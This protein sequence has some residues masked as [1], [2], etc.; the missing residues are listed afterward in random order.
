MRRRRGVVAGFTVLHL[1]AEDGAGAGRGGATNDD[2]EGGAIGSEARVAAAGAVL[3]QDICDI[4]QRAGEQFR[5]EAGGE[6]GVAGEW[7]E[8]VEDQRL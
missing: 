4:R 7:A 6:R 1:D 3:E 5:H 8:Q 2:V